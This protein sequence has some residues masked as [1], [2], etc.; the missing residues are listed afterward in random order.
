M[1]IL[2]LRQSYENGE[3]KHL[4]SVEFP[5]LPDCN[6]YYLGSRYY[7]VTHNWEKILTVEVSPGAMTDYILLHRGYKIR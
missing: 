3:A 1:D 5:E 2:K 6:V 4:Y 7:L